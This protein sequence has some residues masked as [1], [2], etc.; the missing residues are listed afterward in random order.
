MTEQIKEQLRE[1]AERYNSPEYFQQDPIAFPREALR[2]G[3]SLIDVEI[4]AIFAC[5]LA[6]GR[7]EM[8]VRDVSRLMEQMQWRPM[9]YVMSADWRDD[10]TSLHRTIKWSETA[11]V[12]ARLKDWYSNHDTIEGLTQDQIRTMIF[13]SKPDPRSANKKI[14]MMR[15]WMVRRDGKVDLGVWKASD[16]KDLLV[17]LDVHVYTQACELGLTSRKAKDRLTAEEITSA[18]RQVWPEDPLLGDF[19]LFGYGVTNKK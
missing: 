18:F 6:W 9:D 17:P 16:P 8:I 2:R 10:D 14:N 7:R 3:L 15:R 1:W 5:H 11:A 13:A 4:T 19:A 12:C